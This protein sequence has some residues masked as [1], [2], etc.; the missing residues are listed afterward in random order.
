VDI[1]LETGPV[2]KG[3]YELEADTL[4]ICFVLSSDD[5][6]E[7]PKEFKTDEDSNTGLFS[8]ERTR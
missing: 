4:K 1:V 5:D 6:S 8:W 7:R 3:I 2:Y